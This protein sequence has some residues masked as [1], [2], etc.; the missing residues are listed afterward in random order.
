VVRDGRR[1]AFIVVTW[2]WCDSCPIVARWWRRRPESQ[3]DDP[4]VP[5]EQ[6]RKAEGVTTGYPRRH[7]PGVPWKVKPTYPT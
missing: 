2:A 5:L 7:P 4:S 3:I 6:L 1:W